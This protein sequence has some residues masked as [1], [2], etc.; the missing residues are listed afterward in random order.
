MH[1][2]LEGENLL[3]NKQFLSARVEGL[4]ISNSFDFSIQLIISKFSEYS[5]IQ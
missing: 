3:P 5:I 1:A 2:C 4:E